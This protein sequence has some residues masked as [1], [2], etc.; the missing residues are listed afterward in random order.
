MATSKETIDYFL[1]QTAGAGDVR[2]RAMFGEYALYC[3]NKVVGLV[4]D[5]LLCIKV[6]T[7]SEKYLDKS[8]ISP[9]FK[10]A[11][12]FLLV[13]EENWEDRMWLADF[14]K[15]TADNLPTPKIRSRTKKKKPPIR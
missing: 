10:G 3:D 12:N 14:V 6:T 5:N 13:P 7:I 8:H 4:C 11:K 2:A 15:D 9:P 1:D